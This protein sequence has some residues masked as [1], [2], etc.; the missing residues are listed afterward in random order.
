MGSVLA[1][2]GPNGAG[3]TSTIMAIMGHIDI[4]AGRILYDGAEITRRRAVDRKLGIALV[5]E[6]GSSSQT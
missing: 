3:K 2:L 5:P 6:T 1:L 4:H